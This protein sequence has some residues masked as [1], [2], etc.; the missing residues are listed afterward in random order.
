MDYVDLLS[1]AWT[2]FRSHR[3]YI[4][5]GVLLMLGGAGL[6][7]QLLRSF[8]NIRYFE[9]LPSLP[10]GLRALM[11]VNPGLF[12]ILTAVLLVLTF[13]LW[14]ISNIARGALISA[15]AHNIPIRAAWSEA[16]LRGWRLFGIGLICGIPG[17]IA[18]L[19]TGFYRFISAYSSVQLNSL[20][21]DTFSG[22]DAST[23]VNDLFGFN[24]LRVLSVLLILCPLNL[25]AAAFQLFQTLA[26][27]AVMLDDMRLLASFRHGWR[28]FWTHQSTSIPIL[29]LAMLIWLGATIVLVIPES[30]VSLCCVLWP[31]TWLLL[32]ALRSY[33][34]ALWT[35]AWQEWGT[36]DSSSS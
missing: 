16:W 18:L 8:S 2:T 14:L 26:D 24:L 9:N 19:I 6:P 30:I 13:P 3:G 17:L 28:V 4:V 21:A 7:L 23:A 20:M 11:L 35:L 15:A 27:R 31:I 32:G 36:T 29:F 10:D 1:R 5:L 25:F 34:S 12:I 22:L 33:L